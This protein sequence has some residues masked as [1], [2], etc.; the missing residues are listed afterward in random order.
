MIDV[1]A[2]GVNYPDVAQRKGLY[3]PPPGASDL[4][5]LEVSGRVAAVGEGVEGWAIG[6]EV[7]ALTNGGGYAESVAVPAGQCL[8]LPPGVSM[9]DAAGLP[10]T[11]FTVWANV[12]LGHDWP[13]G[14]RFLIHGGSGGIGSTAVQLASA[15]GH[16]VFATCSAAKQAF[17]EGLGAARAIDYRAEDF[18]EIVKAAGGAD[19]I[20]D[21]LGGDY[22]ARNMA[23]AAPEA[24]IVSVAFNR[25]AEVTVNLAPMML[26]RLTLT[27]S[28][29]RP[30]TAEFKARLAGELRETVWPI[31]GNGG[32]RPVTFAT[33]RLDEAAE[34]HRAMEAGEHSGKIILTV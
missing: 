28:T 2:A 4:P 10:E 29:L 26:K 25:G 22:V 7:C 3:P 31:F 23:A 24:R 30:R 1:A 19:L 20:L 33:Y 11:F 5:G 34:A 13:E 16:E 12:F 21:M 9:M 15:M 18:V 17:V 6:N 27:G 14:S 32:I 8:P